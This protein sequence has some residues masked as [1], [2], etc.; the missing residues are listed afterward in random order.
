M[1]SLSSHHI[2]IV[3]F[4]HEEK[5]F[6]TLISLCSHS[7]V[8]K[9]RQGT[10]GRASSSASPWAFIWGCLNSWRWQDDSVGAIHL[11]L[12]SS[13]HGVFWGWSDIATWFAWASSAWCA[14]S[15]GL[16]L[17]IYQ[18]FNILSLAKFSQQLYEFDTN[19]LRERIFINSFKN[20]Y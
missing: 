12:G 19:V 2:P 17:C 10:V 15:V 3:F 11:G 13:L 8:W 9:V 6:I 18:V 5:C 1:P 20:I 14:Q 16:L 4:S 7:M